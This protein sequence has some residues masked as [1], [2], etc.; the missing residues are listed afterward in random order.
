LD[1]RVR[2]DFFQDRMTFSALKNLLSRTIQ[3]YPRILQ[4]VREHL[5]ARGTFW[6][7][8]NIAEVSLHERRGSRA[9]LPL[10][11]P[12]TPERDAAREFARHLAIY[13]NQHDANGRKHH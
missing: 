9:A 8:A 13:K 10:P 5:G 6:W 1:D 7:L 4:R 12:G 3:L 2:R 11:E